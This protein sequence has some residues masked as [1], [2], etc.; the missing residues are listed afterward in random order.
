M[1]RPRFRFDP[2]A[3]ALPYRI[4]IGLGRHQGE[5]IAR[6]DLSAGEV[7][8]LEAHRAPRQR[9]PGHRQDATPVPRVVLHNED[10]RRRRPPEGGEPA[11]DPLRRKEHGAARALQQPAPFRRAGVK[12]L[13]RL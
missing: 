8:Q 1:R 11:R 12:L 6:G 4:V 5:M 9:G 7:G 2:G 13:V 3:H 10:R